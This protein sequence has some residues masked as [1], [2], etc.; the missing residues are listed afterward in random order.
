MRAARAAV[1]DER[2]ALALPRGK[3]ATRAQGA[4]ATRL[5]TTL[6]LINVTERSE[7]VS[8]LADLRTTQSR[9]W[10]M[11]L[12]AFFSGLALLGGLF[13]LLRVIRR[14]ARAGADAQLAHLEKAATTDPLTGLRNRRTFEED[15]AKALSKGRVCLVMLDLDDLKNTNERLGHAVG[16]ER[17]RAVSAALRS[18]DAAAL[19]YRLGGDE[20]AA[21]LAGLGADAGHRFA[22]RVQDGM[23]LQHGGDEPSVAVGVAVGEMRTPTDE[24]V[25]RADTALLAAKRMSSQIRVHSPELD[26][27]ALPTIGGGRRQDVLAAS[28]AAAVDAKD[29]D[30]YDHSGTVAELAGAIAELLGL[31]REQVVQVRTAGLLH[32]VGYLDVDDQIFAKGEPPSDAEWDEIASHAERGARILARCGFGDIATWVRHHHERVDGEGYPDG[33]AGEAIPLESRILHVA[34]AYEAMT[35]GHSYQPVMTAEAA[36]AELERLAGSQFDLQCVAALRRV[37]GRLSADASRP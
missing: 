26:I 16:D 2:R 17:I 35:R 15:L 27:T 23:R 9:A 24:L 11:T 6:K 13:A 5:T 21:I 4:A 28:L 7:A 25:R 18:A 32:D 10:M 19:G 20:F 12:T 36:M 31:P 34:D 37:A 30:G 14:R 22:H 8:G 33:F 29:G 3:A 1:A